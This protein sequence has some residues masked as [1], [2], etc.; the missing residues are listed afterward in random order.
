[1]KTK[2]HIKVT[3]GYQGEFSTLIGTADRGLE[4]VPTRASGG[5]RKTLGGGIKRRGGKKRKKKKP[6][7]KR[8]PDLNP[9]T[10]FQTAHIKGKETGGEKERQGTIE[11]FTGSARTKEVTCDGWVG[12][13]VFRDMGAHKR[14]NRDERKDGRSEA[15]ARKVRWAPLEKASNARPTWEGHRHQ[16]RKR[17]KPQKGGERKQK[18]PLTISWDL[19]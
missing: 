2:R 12:D 3:K 9:L 18:H 16:I 11:S 8:N 7:L 15:P 6:G 14:K 17:R 13:T 10:T 5:E 1:V 19:D 4:V